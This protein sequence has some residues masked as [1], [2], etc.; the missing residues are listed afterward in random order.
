[1]KIRTSFVT[2]SSSSSFLIVG[3]KD[4]DYNIELTSN[5]KLNILRD[6]NCCY[7]GKRIFDCEDEVCEL[8]YKDIQ[9]AFIEAETMLSKEGIYNREVKLFSGKRYC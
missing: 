8:S 2:N 6:Y 5:S 9:K 1:M 4:E 7:V 3:I